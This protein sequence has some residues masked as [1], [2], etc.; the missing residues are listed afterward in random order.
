MKTTIDTLTGKPFRYNTTVLYQGKV[1]PARVTSCSA[2]HLHPNRVSAELLAE[3]NPP[4]QQ[5]QSDSLQDEPE[6]TGTSLA[7]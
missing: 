4:A 3:L 7:P 1:V 2:T 6:N 5:I